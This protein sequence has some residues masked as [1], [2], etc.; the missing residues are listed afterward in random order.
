MRPVELSSRDENEKSLEDLGLDPG[1]VEAVRVLREAGVETTE[2]CQ[3]GKGHAFPEPTIRFC[4]DYSEGFRAL[5]VAVR[6]QL[7][8][9]SL[10]R[11]W[12]MQ[13]GEPTGPEWEMVFY[14]RTR[15]EPWTPV[16]FLDQ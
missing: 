6:A 1:I 4:G 13:N 5:A 10:R 12:S 16:G 3:G 14:S 2:S 15:L 9:S 11:A 8:V 7:R